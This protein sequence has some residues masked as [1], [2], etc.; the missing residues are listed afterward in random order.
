LPD[1]EAFAKSNP[2]NPAALGLLARAYRGLGKE[3]DA[4]RA[5]ERAAALEKK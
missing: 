2:R 4:K 3:Q 1:L 5:E